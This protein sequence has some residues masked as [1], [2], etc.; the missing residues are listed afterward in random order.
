MAP[1]GHRAHP[2]PM[3]RLPT[4]ILLLSAEPCQSDYVETVLAMEAPSW[5]EV[6][7][8]EAGPC[9]GESVDLC[10]VALDAGSPVAADALLALPVDPARVPTIAVSPWM[11]GVAEV[12]QLMRDGA[13]DVLGLAELSPRRLV[14]AIV[15]A[16]AR[17]ARPAAAPRGMHRAEA[18]AGIDSAL[19]G[20]HPWLAVAGAALEA[21]TAI[22]TEAP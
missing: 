17:Q 15:K 19:P 22:A 11:P 8:G 16:L 20:S 1:Y 14:A 6:R 9:P 18:V 7:R 5:F 3:T 12:R 13:E 4:R 2:L 21:G 10:I